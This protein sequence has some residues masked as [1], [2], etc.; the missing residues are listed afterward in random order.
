ML[1]EVLVSALTLTLVGG[2]DRP[3]WEQQSPPPAPVMTPAPPNL[4]HP[5][6]DLL[7]LAIQLDCSEL[8]DGKRPASVYVTISA[9]YVNPTQSLV[10][11]V[12][13]D[14][15][16]ETHDIAENPQA[17]ALAIRCPPRQIMEYDTGRY[18]CTH[19]DIQIGVCSPGF[20]PHSDHWTD[21]SSCGRE[22]E[23]PSCASL[24]AGDASSYAY[25]PIVYKLTPKPEGSGVSC[26]DA[27]ATLLADDPTFECPCFEE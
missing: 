12:D 27:P 3:E 19:H 26:G 23:Q 21:F 8:G 25:A 24:M 6:G 17:M 13:S 5:L 9:S 7:P 1:R 22:L 10:A 2:C 18:D 20:L 11:R 14:T 15:L 16:C 4:M